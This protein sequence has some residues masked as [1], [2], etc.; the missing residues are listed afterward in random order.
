M[1]KENLEQIR[2]LQAWARWVFC[3]QFLYVSA[4]DGMHLLEWS[5]TNELGDCQNSSIGECLDQSKSY[6][7]IWNSETV[8]GMLVLVTYML[9]YLLLEC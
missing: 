3:K 2:E 7:S 5:K 6:I 8:T 4:F 1:F 9:C